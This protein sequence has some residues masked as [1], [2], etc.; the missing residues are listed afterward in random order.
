MS[1]K[2]SN[3][4]IVRILLRA[5][6]I[7]Y[8]FCQISQQNDGSLL[9]VFP[10]MNS[11]QKGIRQDYRI[12]LTNGSKALLGELQ[13]GCLSR[14]DP[15][16][17]YHTTGT[18]TYR[19][20]SFKNQYFE[21]LSKI[22]Q[23]NPF[24]ITYFRSMNSFKQAKI[25]PGNGANL[26]IDVTDVLENGVDVVFSVTPTNFIEAFEPPLPCA[27]ALHYPLFDL[28]IEFVEDSGF[29]CFNESYNSGDVVKIRPKIELYPKQ[30]VRIVDA[31]L[32]Y[33]HLLYQTK[34]A[35]IKGPNGEGTIEAI[36]SNEMRRAPWI[37]IRFA[38]KTLAIDSKSI[39]RDRSELNRARIRFKVRNKDTRQ[40]IKDPKS[41]SIEE[42]LLDAEIYE[43]ETIPPDGFL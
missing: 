33:H 1:K 19:E 43:D 22:T 21:P 9:C 40:I 37:S 36:F 35:I 8:E 23:L 39:E 17:S 6:T 14:M 26:I 3:N 15:H 16:V 29:L 11:T 18:V 12:D 34:A 7:L 38:D 24:F 4:G 30:V 13:D 5:D 27:V 10:N 32:D 20:M 2:A 31:Y 25:L 41:L 28:M 42:V